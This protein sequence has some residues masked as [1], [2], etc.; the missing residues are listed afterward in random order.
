MQTFRLTS[1]EIFDILRGCRNLCRKI[2]KTL[3]QDIDLTL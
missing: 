2:K 1:R 3:I